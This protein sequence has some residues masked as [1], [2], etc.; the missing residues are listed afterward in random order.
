M[1]HAAQAQI[2]NGKS[3]LFPDFAHG[4]TG[5]ALAALDVP[6]RKNEA[7][8]VALSALLH[9]DKIGSLLLHHHH[10]GELCLLRP[11]AHILPLRRSSPAM[12]ATAASICRQF[13]PP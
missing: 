5:E 12:C 4:G 6:A 7:V 2:F 1:P 3:R 11:C 13:A 9:D 10:D 8:P